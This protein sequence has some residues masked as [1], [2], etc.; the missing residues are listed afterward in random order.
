MQELVSGVSQMGDL[1][2]AVSHAS[3]KQSTGIAQI[4]GAV[5]QID[6][7]TQQNA[8]LAEESAAAAETLRDGTGK[9]RQAVGI[10]ALARARHLERGTALTIGTSL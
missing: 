3:Q 6:A 7:M 5:A 9:V 4:N 8:A 10:F 1:V 2:R